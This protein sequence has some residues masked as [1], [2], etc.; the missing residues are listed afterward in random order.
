LTS[1][2][3]S[4]AT[5]SNAQNSRRIVAIR[6]RGY[7]EYCRCSEQYTTESFTVE[8]IKP[9]NAGGETSVENLAWSCSGCNGH[10][11]A[12][13]KGLDLETREKIALYNPRQQL[14]RE[15]F[16]WAGKDAHPTRIVYFLQ[17]C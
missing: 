4:I 2:Y 16:E 8:H 12:K 6:A 10:K 3:L 17:G 1:S 9:K 15:H 5:S 13:I 7:C 14:W 11:H